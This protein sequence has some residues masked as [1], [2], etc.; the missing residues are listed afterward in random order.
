MALTSMLKICILLLCYLA[1]VKSHSLQVQPHSSECFF[2]EVKQGEHFL[3][4]YEV[5]EADGAIDF[6]VTDDDNRTIHWKSSQSDDMFSVD[7]PAD[8]R[9]TY[10]FINEDYKSEVRTVM[11]NVHGNTKASYNEE[12][13]D[14]A[15]SPVENEIYRLREGIYQVRDEQQ[16][17]VMRER[18]HRNTCESTNGRVK[19]WSFIQSG[20]L[21]SACA[22]QVIYLK[23]FFEAKRKSR[24]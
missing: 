3:I 7:V 9:Y 23:R 15:V 22:F 16:Y 18:T 10:C 14:S 19:W 11:W 12:V 1:V 2:E 13:D 20:V 17:I 24:I 21:I 5:G 4:S 8:G 6:R